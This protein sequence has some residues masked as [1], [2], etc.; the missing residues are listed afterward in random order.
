M[1]ET[2]RLRIDLSLSGSPPQSGEPSWNV[3]EG[4]PGLLLLWLETHLGIVVEERAITERVTEYAGLLEKAGGDSY[5]GSLETNRL[6]T[7]ASLL[8]LRDE[9]LVSGWDGKGRAGLPPL[10]SDLAMVEKLYGPQDADTSERIRSI[11]CALD[12]GRTLPSHICTLIDE[13]D[14]W[15][16]VWRPLL[17][18]L[19]IEPDETTT[20]AAERG[21]AL[22]ASQKAV[23]GGKPS[24]VPFDRS[25]RSLAGT[26]I[27]TIV[28]TIAA[29]LAEDQ[30]ALS[31]TVI[32]CD[33]PNVALRLDS[34]LHRLGLPTMGAAVNS[35][36]LPVLQILPLVL[37]LCWEPVDPELLLD[38]ISLPEGPIPRSAGRRLADALAERPGLG[39]ASWDEAIAELTGT[40][41]DPDG[42]TAERLRL[43]L[44]QKRIARNDPLPPELVVDRCSKIAQWA[45]ARASVITDNEEPTGFENSL[46]LL[47]SQS[48]TLS[49][50][51]AAQNEAISEPQLA[52][53]LETAQ[54]GGLRDQPFAELEG[55]P[56]LVGSLAEIVRPAGRL[57]WI[58]TGTE[59]S[60][61]SRWTSLERKSLNEN[62]V[63]IDDGGRRLRVLRT[64]ERR[65]FLNIRDHLL[66][67]SLPGDD[68]I[69]PHPLLL[70]A[71]TAITGEGEEKPKPVSLETLL[72]ENFVSPILPWS[73]QASSRKIE[74]PQSKRPLWKVTRRLLADRK[75][76]S[77]SSLGDRLACPLKWTFNYQARLR[78]SPIAGLPD[79]FQLKGSFCHQILEDVF[80]GGGKLPTE[81]RALQMVGDRFDKRIALDAAPLT[82]PTMWAENRQLRKELLAATGTLVKTL[83][84][85]VYHIKGMEVQVTGK[86]HNRALIGSIDCLAVRESGDEAVIDFKYGGRKKYPADLENGRAVQLAT[87]AAARAHETGQRNVPVA[88]L[89]LSNAEL[90]TPEGSPVAGTGEKQHVGGAPPIG[91]VWERFQKAIRAADGWLSGEEPIP[92]RPLQNPETWPEGSGLVLDEESEDQKVCQY[93]DYSV[94][95][96]YRELL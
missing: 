73:F 80:G 72:M 92:A 33:D 47:A 64:A 55:A 4:G 58:G 39:S 57:L 25:L 30:D 35:V 34:S 60:P 13:P 28:E 6:S 36:A 44:E 37:R 29:M 79:S 89:I 81:T 84:A 41:N 85:G 19:R 16:P 76:S 45:M 8:S 32:C 54:E 66:L 71:M 59:D 17:M 9:L 93:C 61:S 38:F 18:R 56:V 42:K 78:S 94:L 1:S 40:E 86:I 75:Q 31:S 2:C 24:P 82:Q 11:L 22:H 91:D 53:L 88:Y 23:A 26:S 83:R 5:S 95:C 51:A 74:S 15:P 67:I 43:W 7:A 63:E 62:G 90:Y 77:A 48:S 3:V 68:E 65:G 27:H 21:S 87:Y 70:Q 46:R 50:M 12:S 14:Q 96:G 20:P 69:R 52:R 49:A 10:V